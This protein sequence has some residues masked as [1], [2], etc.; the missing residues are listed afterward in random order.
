MKYRDPEEKTDS[1]VFIHNV[2]AFKTSVYP[3]GKNAEIKEFVS[4]FLYNESDE[5]MKVIAELTI[6]DSWMKDWKKETIDYKL[7]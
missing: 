4:I 1:N 6:S 2:K 3:S 7:G 5:D